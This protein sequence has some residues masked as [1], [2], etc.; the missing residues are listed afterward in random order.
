MADKMFNK[1]VTRFSLNS[2]K[3]C[4]EEILSVAFAVE[5]TISRIPIEAKLEEINEHLKKLDKKTKS[6]DDKPRKLS[7][8]NRFVKIHL[9]EIA[10]E[11]P[12]M[13]NNERMTKVSEIW[14]KTSPE[15]RQKYA[16]EE[17]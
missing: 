8:Y 12:D 16:V 3:E 2:K 7:V 6:S 15:E 13:K 11:F 1:E 10:K 14:K 9:P 4:L 5:N 17:A